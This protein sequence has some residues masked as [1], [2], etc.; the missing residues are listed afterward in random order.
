MRTSKYRSMVGREFRSEPE[1]YELPHFQTV[2]VRV[3]LPKANSCVSTENGWK[4]FLF[5][6]LRFSLTA[7]NR[8]S[9]LM[10]KT[11]GDERQVG[12]T[13]LPHEKR[14]LSL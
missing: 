7:G 14:R 11:N 12:K 5:W 6:R 8:Q 2:F 10:Q 13:V 3:V 1:S 9:C 4:C